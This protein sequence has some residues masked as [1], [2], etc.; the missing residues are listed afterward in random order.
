MSVEVMLR[1]LRP[2]KGATVL[3][4]GCGNGNL[5]HELRDEGLDAFGCDFADTSGSDFSSDEISP[6]LRPLP[7]NHYR[8]PFEDCCF[9]YVISSQVLEHVRDYPTTFAEI[10]RV[11]KPGGV[12]L[13]VFPSRYTPVEPH[14]RIPLATA[15]QSRI[16]LYIWALFGIRSSFQRGK[17]AREVTRL[18]YNYLREQTNYLTRQQILHHASVFSESA[19]RERDLFLPL[20]RDDLGLP[21]L[22]KRLALGLLGTNLVELIYSTFFMRALY[23]KK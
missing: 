5:V 13:H 4:L 3:D 11:L 8:I 16:W 10:R 15:I 6:F 23:L 22:K 7:Q 20:D 2:A 21:S 17:S 18:N 1:R 12:S 9:D 14:V 19:F